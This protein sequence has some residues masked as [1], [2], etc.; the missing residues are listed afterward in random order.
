MFVPDV[1]RNRNG[2]HNEPGFENPHNRR[3]MAL[4]VEL[5]NPNLC[6]M[7]DAVTMT[8]AAKENY[9]AQT[10]NEGRL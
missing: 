5:I 10:A 7:N 3:K 6:I 9:L 8:M 1:R 2:N 4:A